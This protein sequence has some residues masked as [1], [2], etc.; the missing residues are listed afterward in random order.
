M[1]TC[2]RRAGQQ[3]PTDAAPV[4]VGVDA[5]AGAGA[6]V[7]VPVTCAAEDNNPRWFRAIVL[8]AS[9]YLPHGL[10]AQPAQVI[11]GARPS[12]VSSL[13]S[14]SYPGAPLALCCALARTGALCRLLARD[15]APPAGWAARP[16]AAAACCELPAAAR[17]QPPTAAAAWSLRLR[18]RLRCA[19]AALPRPKR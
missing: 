11:A 4:P 19:A 8:K 6:Q 3:P 16:G 10:R 2:A 14:L 17:A 13:S 15:A 5:R 12:R 18:L 1:G 9:P 7:A